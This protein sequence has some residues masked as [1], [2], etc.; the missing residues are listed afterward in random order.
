MI[1]FQHHVRM[2]PCMPASVPADACQPCCL[3]LDHIHDKQGTS[4]SPPFGHVRL[5]LYTGSSSGKR[6]LAVSS[7]PGR[8]EYFFLGLQ[9]HLH[10]KC[11][12]L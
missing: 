10:P 8:N 11:L 12:C 9:L 5:L 4:M 3:V 1:R 7:V 6:C 2:P